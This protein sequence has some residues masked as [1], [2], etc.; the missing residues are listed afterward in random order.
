MF[1]T[2]TVCNYKGTFCS[3]ATL[4]WEN[5][6]GLI[7]NNTSFR[8]KHSEC[9][10]H[11]LMTLMM[12]YNQTFCRNHQMSLIQIILQV[13]QLVSTDMNVIWLLLNV[14]NYRGL[15]RALVLYS[16]FKGQWYFYS[17]FVWHFTSPQFWRNADSCSHTE[18][19]IIICRL[20]LLEKLLETINTDPWSVYRC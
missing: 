13:N 6:L 1:P 11:A 19:W 17:Y 20:L 2:N 5:V 3:W 12:S 8:I 16:I 18:N 9:Q 15:I 10:I 14:L 4:K 7:R